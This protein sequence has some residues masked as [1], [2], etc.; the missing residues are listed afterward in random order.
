MAELPAPSKHARRLQATGN[1]LQGGEH[2]FT[3]IRF[4]RNRLIDFNPISVGARFVSAAV[5]KSEDRSPYAAPPLAARIG[6]YRDG[7]LAITNFHLLLYQRNGL[8]FGYR[9]E[10]SFWPAEVRSITAVEARFAHPVSIVFADGS[11]CELDADT[12]RSR[13]HLFEVL[14]ALHTINAR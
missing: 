1:G 13:H 4:H 2:V 5:K 14:D 10:V 12:A 3:A 6:Q 9:P 7:L 11:S 8:L